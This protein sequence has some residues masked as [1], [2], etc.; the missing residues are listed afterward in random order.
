MPDAPKNEP[1]D[2]KNRSEK[3]EALYAKTV[4]RYARI[5]ESRQE[6][7]TPRAFA[8]ALIADGRPRTPGSWRLY[9]TAIKW[10][11]RRTIGERAAE[12]FDRAV[13]ALDPPRA[14]RRR[15]VKRLPPDVLDLIV[16]SLRSSPTKLRMMA[17]DALI[18]ISLTG[19]RP[20][21][22]RAAVLDGDLL[23]VQNAKYKPGVRANGPTRTLILDRAALRTGEIEAIERTLEAFRGFDWE[24]RADHLRSH[25]RSAVDELVAAKAIPPRYAK[26]R[27][28]DAR[29]QF[30]ADAKASLEYGKGEVAGALGHISA[31]TAHVHYGR[32]KSAAGA[33]K[34]RPA[35]ESVAAVRQETLDNLSAA[36]N[37]TSREQSASDASPSLEREP[38]PFYEPTQNR[39]PDPETDPGF[40][41][42]GPGF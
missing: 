41:N 39:S 37:R 27:L 28:Y 21:E 18:A 4:R 29:H 36:L 34:V 14:K 11:L 20:I 12:D 35:P 30:S 22:W 26:L 5:I 13:K 19:L 32:R 1:L 2:A 24:T 40:G 15:L 25:I 33:T 17:A 10:H 3:T 23:H 8:E 9:R 31:M 42:D 38:I 6:P 16:S 7:A